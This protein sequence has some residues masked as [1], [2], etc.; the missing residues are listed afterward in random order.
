MSNKKIM[1]ISSNDLKFEAELLWDLAP[2]TCQALITIL[3][4][5]IKLIHVRW[6]GFGVFSDFGEVDVEEVPFENNTIHF[7]IGELM[8]Y[9]GFESMK[10]L[11][12]PYGHVAFA[13]KAGLHPG[14]HFATIKDTTNLP[15]LGRRAIEEGIQPVIFEI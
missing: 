11:L 4:L 6:S 5:E 3:P 14:N 8:F 15:E 2:K 12:I 10:E 1:R 9:P 7:S 13:S